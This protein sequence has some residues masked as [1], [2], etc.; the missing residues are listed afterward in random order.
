MIDTVTNLILCFR[1]RCLLV[2]IFGLLAS[3]GIAEQP[4]V[5]VVVGAGGTTE[6]EQ[7]FSEWAGRI[8]TTCK[9]AEIP[10]RVIGLD[11]SDSANDRQ[12]TLEAIGKARQGDQPLWLVFLGHGTSF[13]DT[14]KFNLRG[15]D[16]STKDLATVI[17]EIERPIISIVCASSSAPFLKALTGP[18][19]VVITATKS[20]S[21]QNYSRFGDF[22]SAAIADASADLDHDDQVSALEAFLIASKSVSRFYESES[23]IATET[24]LIEDNGDGLGTT[25]EFFDGVRIVAKAQN[26][27]TDGSFAHQFVLVK[28]DRELLF[29]PEM[30]ET[31]SQLEMQIDKLRS[32]KKLYSTDEY[33]ALLEPLM[34]QLAELYS[35][36]D[37]SKPEAKGQGAKP[38]ATEKPAATEEEIK[39]TE[40]AEDSVEEASSLSD[41]IE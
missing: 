16:F 34:L 7:K 13:K 15:P 23:R 4:A 30:L 31:R 25:S 18:N 10:H 6:Y 29:S 33:F 40:G 39:T 21:E 26:G 36:V 27:K 32:E 41:S 24:A 12:L 17:K 28:N 35:K 22:F 14:T 20:G 37:E 1:T 2:G 5:I 11:K 9:Q 8:V 38:V 3:K 19:R